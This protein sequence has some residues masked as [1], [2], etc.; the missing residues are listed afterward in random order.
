MH[1]TELLRETVVMVGVAVTVVL[2]CCRLRLPT[3]VGLLVTG[4]LVGPHSLGLVRD[5]HQVEVLAEIGV[6][7]LLFSIGLELSVQQLLRLRAALAVAGPI[8]VATCGLAV[9]AAARLGGVAPREAI[10]LGMLGA[11]SSTAVVLT[12]FESRG[13][14]QTP[15][16]RV[17]LGILVFQDLLVVPMM[18]LVPLLAA[19]GEAAGATVGALL[20]PIAA[21]VVGVPLLARVVVPWLLGRV[22][23]VRDRQLF[24]LSIVFIALAV[25]WAG[26]ALGLSLALGA[27]LAGLVVSESEYSHRALGS[28]L[29]FRDLLT[30]FFFIS[31]GM[32]LDLGELW[33]D[34]WLV[35]AATAGLIAVK[36]LLTQLAVL[37]IGYPM[38][39][40]VTTG[41]TLAQV[42]EFSFVLLGAGTVHGLLEGELRQLVLAVAV[43]SM[44]LTPA[45][46]S[47]A[48]HLAAW[49]ARLPG[50]SRFDRTDD[51]PADE[52]ADHLIAVGYGIVGQNVVQAARAAGIPYLIV[53]LNPDT[54]SRLRR[55]GEPVLHGDAAQEAVLEHAGI[56]R[57]R[58][59]VVAIAD[60]AAT[61][62]ITELARR[63][64]PSLHVIARTRFVQEIEALY[65]LG[66][67]DVIPEEFETAM[68]IFARVL[69]F[70]LVPDDQIDELLTELRGDGYQLLR[71]GRATLA[72]ASPHLAEQDIATLTV[73]AGSD[74]DGRSLA[75]LRPRQ[76]H[77]V[78][79]LAVRGAAGL[80]ATPDGE[81]RLGAED[82]VV[83]MGSR[84]TLAAVGRHLRPA[85]EDR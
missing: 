60:A 80:N 33:Q 11:V 84:D 9:F 76:E 85:Q 40:A 74:W 47:A 32:L 65:A 22:A 46:M 77:G 15:A 48:P 72:Q 25:A 70:Y 66:A 67:D 34:I 50:A 30:G 79:V 35:L 56:A 26:S 62:R 2:L 69:T 20:L 12:L 75:E 64:N 78:I 51:A 61:R 16:G 31:I 10:F 21:C 49:I 81:T 28:V 27:F 41:V 43:I 73:G 54:T 3:A 63:L 14:S 6:I 58:V 42:G 13:E 44:M 52:K 71:P 57:A 24:L 18:L 5:V 82:Q 4:V 29:P 19:G 55:E 36:A 68:A 17:S 37:I 53:E 38:R 83:L 39:T 45:L 7:A 23:R 1:G 8:Q 59:L